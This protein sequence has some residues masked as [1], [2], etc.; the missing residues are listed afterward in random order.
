MAWI[1]VV[2]NLLA[3][4]KRN[5]T[6]NQNVNKRASIW[7]V[8]GMGYKKRTRKHCIAN[9]NSVNGGFEKWY[10]VFGF[11]M[12][13]KMFSMFRKIP[14][15]DAFRNSVIVIGVSIVYYVIIETVFIV[16]VAAAI[17]CRHRI[18]L[19]RLHILPATQRNPIPWWPVALNLCVACDFQFLIR[20][21]NRHACIQRSPYHAIRQNVFVLF[22]RTHTT[23][24][25][26]IVF[27]LYTCGWRQACGSLCVRNA[28]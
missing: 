15:D 22:T 20:I 1:S 25:N 14:W 5:E 6:K 26:R 16:V 18:S 19:L 2:N 4:A 10:D 11:G 8:P 24:N 7:W 12:E 13:K 21:D 23:T 17:A 3:T 27:T 9:N 28:W